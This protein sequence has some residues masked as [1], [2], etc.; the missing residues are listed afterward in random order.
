MAELVEPD[1]PSEPSGTDLDIGDPLLWEFFDSAPDGV[2]VVDDS[3]RIRAVNRQIELLFGYDRTS[4]IG[5]TVEVLL[6]GELRQAHRAHR[7]RYRADPRARPMGAGLKLKGRRCDGTAFPIEISLSPVRTAREPLVIAAVRDIS[8]RVAAQTRIAEILGVLDGIEDALFLFDRESLLFTYVNQGA[9]EQ[10]GYSAEELS[11]MTMVHLAPELDRDEFAKLVLSLDLE[12]GSSHRMTSVHRRK[13]GADIPV[14]LI[15]QAPASVEGLAPPPF[16]AIAR[17]M[18]SRLD[19]EKRLRDTAEQLAVAEEREQIASELHDTVIQRIFASGMSLQAALGMS[20]DPLVAE[21]IRD[22]VDQLDRTIRD[23]RSAIFR[24]HR[25]GTRTRQL[26]DE[27]LAVLNE[28]RRTLG[29]EPQVTF[30]GPIETLS[31]EIAGVLVPALRGLLGQA[32]RHARATEISVEI[33]VGR[34]VV[35][36]V[37]D[38]GAVVSSGAEGGNLLELMRSAEAL[39]GTFEVASPA[40][41][42]TDAVWRVPAG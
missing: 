28:S 3:G 20:R 8:E 11:Q 36:R 16:V 41:G 1:R 27:I 34:D 7:T 4:L 12:K 13:D 33:V 37:T 29:F 40:T 19:A 31:T 18:R 35:L 9:V 17:D 21:R 24:L 5:E 15:I 23:V 25:P 32:A 22:V 30:E 39:A 26:R 10:V 42:G 14:E 6:P 2:L 38:N